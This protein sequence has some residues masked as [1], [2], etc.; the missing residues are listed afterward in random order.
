M[1]SLKARR[2]ALPR[3]AAS[4]DAALWRYVGLLGRAWR[5]YAKEVPYALREQH[6][7]LLLAARDVLLPHVGGGQEAGDL[8]GLL[9]ALAGRP[10][11]MVVATPSVAPQAVVGTAP[12]TPQPSVPRRAPGTPPKCLERVEEDQQQEAKVLGE[13][14]PADCDKAV[15]VTH[16]GLGLREGL[17]METAASIPPPPRSQGSFD[18]ALAERMRIA[19]RE[20]MTRRALELREELVADAFEEAESDII[21]EDMLCAVLADARAVVGEVFAEFAAWYLSDPV[22]PPD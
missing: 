1:A 21:D 13:A 12:A 2:Q 16:R 15:S 11:A 7:S 19:A 17:D 14:H 18:H 10:A 5:L 20:S 3:R 8:M 22:Q 9:A 4:G 6:V